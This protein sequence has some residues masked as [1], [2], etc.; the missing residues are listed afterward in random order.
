MGN[1]N[2]DKSSVQSCERKPNVY[3]KVL[4]KCQETGIPLKNVRVSLI[5]KGVQVY[6]IKT[7][8]SGVALFKPGEKDKLEGLYGIRFTLPDDIG[9]KYYSLQQKNIDVKQKPVIELFK[10]EPKKATIEVKVKWEGGARPGYTVHLRKDGEEDEKDDLPEP[11]P[12]AG[13]SA[14]LSS[15][16]ELEHGTY[17]VWL[18]L[19][20]EDG[21][22]H[23]RIPENRTVAVE[24]G[25]R[26]K[27]KIKLK[28]RRATLEIELM[29]AEDHPIPEEEYEIW[30]MGGGARKITGGKLDK[31]G[32]AHVRDRGIVAGSAYEIRF[33]RYD[34]TDIVTAEED[35]ELYEE[36][37]PEEADEP[38][39]DYYGAAGVFFLD[40]KTGRA[41][42]S[43][44]GSYIDH[45]SD[46]LNERDMLI[47]PDGKKPKVFYRLQRPEN[48]EKRG[49]RGRRR[50][51]RLVAARQTARHFDLCPARRQRDAVCRARGP[52]PKGETAR[53]SRGQGLVLHPPESH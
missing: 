46:S 27:V 42:P 30:T 52:A 7:D 39:K 38:A 17:V 13:E 8:K 49:N 4:V 19:N 20:D 11:A 43:F 14:M 26:E 51:N 5:K 9:R 6:E 41:T 47:M 25:G 48:I 21:E 15:Y 34:V 22:E 37:A 16:T 40:E 35:E 24:P 36:E 2:G 1:G 50:R 3:V 12:V 45:D 33:P 53:V 28:E 31:Q 29:D 10:L 23:Y 44:R 32:Q 18:T